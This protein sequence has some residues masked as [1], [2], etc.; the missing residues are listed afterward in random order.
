MDCVYL[1]HDRHWRRAILNTVM[2]LRF[3]PKVG[4]E[5]ESYSYYDMCTYLFEDVVLFVTVL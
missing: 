2:K 1:R 3:P 4:I 5:L